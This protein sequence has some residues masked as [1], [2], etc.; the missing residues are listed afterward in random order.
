[1]SYELI[2][3]L[4]LASMRLATGRNQTFPRALGSP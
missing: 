1:M 3:I 2:A 4:M